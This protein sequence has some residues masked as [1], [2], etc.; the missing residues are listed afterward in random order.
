MDCWVIVSDAGIVRLNGFCSWRF[1]CDE[2]VSLGRI[3]SAAARVQVS[4]YA[5]M[6]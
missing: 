5:E 1:G 6:R 3:E 2:R 4:I